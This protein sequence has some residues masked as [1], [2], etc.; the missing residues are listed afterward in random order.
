MR[1]ESEQILH[2]AKDRSAKMLQESEKE[3]QSR[4]SLLSRA[5]IRNVLSHGMKRAIHDQLMEDLLE[6]FERLDIGHV[7]ESTR[8][9]KVVLSQPLS[10]DDR[11]RIEKILEK[12]IGRKIAIR[13]TVR[14]EMI[15]GMI[16]SLDSLVM[17]GS[18]ESKLEDALQHLTQP[19]EKS[20]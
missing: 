11:K 15:G 18:L 7:S 1:E 5:A 17:D 8:E 3:Q 6:E 20:S 10:V 19:V 2:A 4:A 13:E 16:L 9:A 12:K 14:E